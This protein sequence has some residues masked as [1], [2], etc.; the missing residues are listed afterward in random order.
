ML[1]PSKHDLRA[2]K[3]GAPGL[4]QPRTAVRGASAPIAI[5]SQI[6]R[7][8][9]V[10]LVNIPIMREMPGQ[11]FYIVMKACPL[12]A[13]C[14]FAVLLG[15]ITLSVFRTES[16]AAPGFATWQRLTNREMR[17]TL[18][19]SNGAYCRVDVST[20]LAQW[21]GFVTLLSVGS[22]SHTDSAAPYLISRFYRGQELT[23]TGHVT[24]DHLTTT[25]GGVVIHPVYHA[26]L[27]L[28]WNSQ[29]IFVDPATNSFAGLPLADLILFTHNHNDHFNA[30]ATV[31]LLAATGTIIAPPLVYSGLSTPLKARTGVLTN[32]MSTNWLGTLIEAVPMYNLANTPHKKG[33][34]MGFVMTIGGKRLYI[35]GDTQNTTELLALPAIDV[36]F[37]PINNPYTMTVAQAVAATRTFRPGVVY[38]YHYRNSDGSFADLAG[39]KQQVGQDLGI[40]VRLRKWY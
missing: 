22:N 15:L 10:C 31:G 18:T 9:H 35:A 37:L 12:A 7:A 26:S 30:S 25:N 27:A 29:T 11:L 24:G 39:F 14:R 36:A 40:E 19:A 33:D 1:S 32:G 34:G 13:Q 17:L 28:R 38:P 3:W 16:T 4:G 23:G 21:D 6:V 20:N 5:C 2:V 8:L